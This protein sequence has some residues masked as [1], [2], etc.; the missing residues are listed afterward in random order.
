MKTETEKKKDN[1]S[2]AGRPGPLK[3]W[4][5]AMRLRTLPASISGVLAGVAVALQRGH[6]DWLPALLCLLFALAAQI[7]SNFAN[8][9]YDYRDGLDKPGREGFRR[10]VTEGD[11]TPLAMHRAT[12]IAF[13]IAALIGCS[14]IYWGGWWLVLA[15][16][17]IFIGALS[18]SAGPFPLSRNAMGEIAVVIFYGLIPVG[19]T[20]YLQTGYFSYDDF[21]AGLA[22]GLMSANILI[23]NNYRDH[24]DDKAV[25][26]LTTA[27]VFGRNAVAWAY[28]LN[29]FI[30]VALTL[31]MWISAGAITLVFPTLYL[32]AHVCLWRYLR[33]NEGH[34]LNPALGMTAML[35]LLFIIA[36]LVVSAV[37]FTPFS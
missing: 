35:M 19:F 3:V 11:I 27:V 28:L 16:I 31:G 2:A 37:D 32:I 17:F 1:T 6:F 10:G 7:G 14:L 23:V 34:R 21:A 22:V 29:G 9:Y 30:A 13:G 25:N 26:K 8:E 18:Y 20:F 4:I 36:L 33:A 15:G 5:E 12:A 24:D